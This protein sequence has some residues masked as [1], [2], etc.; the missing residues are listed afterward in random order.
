MLISE[1]QK[2]IFIHVQKTAGISMETLLK[3]AIPDLRTWHGRHGHA[4]MGIAEMGKT[5]WDSYF[6][7]AFVRNPWDRLVSWYAMISKARDKLS[8]DA[9]Q[10]AKP[11]KSELWNYAI[12][13]SHD[14]ESFLFNCTAEMYDLGCYKSFAY[15]QIDYISD[16][17]GGLAVDFVG[18]F[19]SLE[20]DFAKIAGRAKIAEVKLPKLNQSPH[21][22]YSEWYSEKTRDLVAQRFARDI[23][24]FDYTFEKL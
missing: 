14:F 6:S 23:E 4:A 21:K 20:E 11:F 3:E 5:K 1:T 17:E 7:F 22:H 24:A 19:E 2:M 13:H 15:N 18:R 9:L 12:K 10:Q 8:H 16:A